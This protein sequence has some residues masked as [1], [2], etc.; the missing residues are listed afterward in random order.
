MANALV[1]RIFDGVLF[2]TR[3]GSWRLS[4]L[5]LQIIE[6]SVRLLAP[7][8]QDRVRRQLEQP[9]FVERT[10]DRVSVIRFY[11]ENAQLRLESS[12]WQDAA[13]NVHI[14]V[15]GAN[16]IAQVTIYK[17]CLFT[18]ELKKPRRFYRNETVDISDVRLG[19]ANRTYTRIIDRAEHGHENDLK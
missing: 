11:N 12:E 18:V 6:A 19:S 13:I 9:L 2:L 8:S 14:R 16:Q 17:G 7:D 3:E 4:P 15:G 10:S 1:R 5:E